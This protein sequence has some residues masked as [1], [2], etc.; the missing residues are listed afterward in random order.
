[1]RQTPARAY[2]P[3]RRV[4]VLLASITDPLWDFL[5]APQAYVVP[6]PAAATVQLDR[7]GYAALIL[8]A[9][10]HSATLLYPADSTTDTRLSAGTHRLRKVSAAER[11]AD[12]MATADAS[13]NRISNGCVNVPPNPLRDSG[14]M[15]TAPADTTPGAERRSSM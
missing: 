7:D 8:V 5:P 13:D 1:M 2:Y 4:P 10:G 9:P 14:G 12:R 11:R 6:P 3:D 15:T